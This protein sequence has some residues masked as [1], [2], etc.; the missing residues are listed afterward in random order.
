M[1]PTLETVLRHD[2]I[3]ATV[4]L[5]IV[6]ASSWAYLLAGAGTMQQMDGML[7]PMRSGPWSLDQAMV[8][9]AMWI[10][11]MVAMMLPSAA[12]MLLLHVAIARRRADSVAPL[13]GAR[14]CGAFAGGYVAIWTLFSIAAVALQFLLERAALLS[15]M[16]TITSV[17]LSAGV[18]IAAGAYQLTT[19]KQA[20]LQRC[21]TP[22]DFVLT[23][24]RPG[25]R[26][27]FVMGLQHGLYCFGCCWL[28][29]LLLFVGGVMN[30]LWIGALALFV[31]L[32]KLLPGGR[33][34][35]R[36]AGLGLIGWGAAALWAA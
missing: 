26:G 8:M 34:M 12:P 14:A 2:R 7:M 32:E 3:V 31:L 16:M 35:G 29:M 4:A 10:V 9:L 21:R 36:I 5:A 15:P 27:A 24:W 11:M 22:L 6:T 19:F 17:T 28:L 25:T 23:H 13:A 18:L 1:L 20:C 33:W 30:L